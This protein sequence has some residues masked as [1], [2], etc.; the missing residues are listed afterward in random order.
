VTALGDSGGWV[1]PARHRR[2]R[3][4][5]LLLCAALLRPESTPARAW[6]EPR[7]SRSPL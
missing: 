3:V 6:S 2:D 7:L 1:D 5:M 4:G